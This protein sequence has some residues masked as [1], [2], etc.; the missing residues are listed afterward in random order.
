MEDAP[1]TGVYPTPLKNNKYAAAIMA[2]PT[3]RYR[4][5]QEVPHVA[6]DDWV[7]QWPQTRNIPNFGIRN[8]TDP[9]RTKALS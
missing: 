6:P 2:D 5:A 1:G 3:N 8:A 4:R 9:L 7:N